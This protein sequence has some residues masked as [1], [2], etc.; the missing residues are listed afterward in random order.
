MDR[1]YS[2]LERALAQLIVEL[3]LILEDLPEDQI[4]LDTSVKLQEDIAATIQELDPEGQTRFVTI[5]NDLAREWDDDE[6]AGSGERAREVL[7]IPS[8]R[9][10]CGTP[11][12]IANPTNRGLLGT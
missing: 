6:W 9:L 3:V 2:T 1:A 5:V 4:E 11:R 10:L 8:R 12:P 7:M